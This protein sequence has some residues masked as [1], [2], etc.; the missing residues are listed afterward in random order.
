MIGFPMASTTR[1]IRRAALHLSLVLSC[2]TLGLTACSGGT[3][4]DLVEESGPEIQTAPVPDTSTDQLRSRSGPQPQ[5]VGGSNRMAERAEVDQE[6]SVAPPMQPAAELGTSVETRSETTLSSVPV[7]LPAMPA[8][9]SLLTEPSAADRSFNQAA[10]TA[11][12]HQAAPVGEGDSIAAP[13]IV[14]DPTDPNGIQRRPGD[15]DFSR[16]DY[17]PIQENDFLSVEDEPLSTFSIDVDAA[18]YSNMRRFLTSG[19][20]P[21][22]DAIR[23]EELI[24]Y[25]NYDY[26]DPSGDT[27]FTV[28]T[29]ISAA[30]WN[31]QHQLVHIGLQGQRLATEDLPP[32]N[33]VFLLDVSGSMNQPSKLPLLKSAFRLLVDELDDQDRVSIVVYAGAAGVV[34][35]PTSGADKPRILEAI[36]RLE[37][38]GS[39]AG[40]A[41]IQRAYDLARQNLLP[42]GNNRVILATDGDFNVGLS[43]ESE[44]VQLIENRREDDIFL[45]VL[46]FGTGNLQDGKMEQLANQGNGTYAYIDSLQEAEKVMVNELGATLFSIA[47]DVKL[48]IEFNPA[49]VQGYRLI[50]YENRVLENYEFNDDTKDAGELGAGHSVTALYE[51]V[52]VGVD[53]DV[54]LPDVDPLR[55]QQPGPLEEEIDP[56]ELMWVKLRY[57]QPTADL[58]QKL[59]HP[60]MNWILAPQQTSDDFRFSAAV[61]GFGMMLRDS[62]Y[63]GSTDLELIREL[64]TG[65]LGT[66]RGGYR[67]EF[68]G[69]VDRYADLK[70][71]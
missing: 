27:P 14:V 66:D 22:R 65:A 31:P 17:N 4:F 34:L 16:E 1:R 46:G 40:G 43:S 47:K 48:Q 67:Q 18:S 28:V 52:P 50:G 15:Q 39:T 2:S 51:I 33:L 61:A 58:S 62:Q 20:I 8:P 3:L 63:K 24:N 7:A 45:T 13:N 64:A 6:A 23:I 30:P 37:A 71:E 36:E 35:E 29:E 9:P 11:F 54:D 38:G 19:Q 10:N 59:E 55:Y 12:R 32:S 69:L 68:V 41:G 21:P 70:G 42:E 26:P 44:L 57:K 56:Q 53:T 25:F 49:Q 60:V 5:P